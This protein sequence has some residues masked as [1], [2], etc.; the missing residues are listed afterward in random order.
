MICWLGKKKKKERERSASANVECMATEMSTH[1]A[2]KLCLYTAGG[3][4]GGGGV[5]AKRR[6]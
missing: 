6:E 4:G 1:D 2:I 3:G 5:E